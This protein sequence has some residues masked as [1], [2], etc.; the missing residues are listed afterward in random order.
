MAQFLAIGICKGAVYAPLALGFGL[1]YT[2]SRVFHIAHGAIYVVAAY[3]LYYFMDVEKLPPLLSVLIVLSLAAILGVLMELIVYRP[4]DK[5]GASAAVLLISSLGAYIFL[6]NLIPMFA[7][8]EPH[9]LLPGVQPTIRIGDIIL[10]RVQLAQVG[11]SVVLI[12]AYWVFLR[13]SFL[14]RLCRAVAGDPVL[15]SVLGIDV[16]GTRLLTFAVG[17]VFAALS[18]VLVA[19]DIGIDPNIGFPALLIAAVACI[20]GGMNRFIAPALGA[21][22]LGLL[23]S[24]VVWATSSKWENAVTFAL[25]ICFLL[26]RPRGLLGT[27]HRLEER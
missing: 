2:T 5:R 6:V 21:I 1:I 8:N 24:L 12:A 9:F 22:L 19:L 26:F 11:L 10:T 15:A 3:S 16:K 13:K 4:L 25:L 14:G 17:S 7:G 27:G 18:A 20:I 23:Q